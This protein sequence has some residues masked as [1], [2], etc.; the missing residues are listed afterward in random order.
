MTN[1]SSS[2]YAPA[3]VDERMAAEIIGVAP[4]T[5]RAFRSQRRGPLFCRIG[6][7]IVYRLPDLEAY[8]A[9]NTVSP[10]I[11]E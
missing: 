5:L 2:R 6:R 10:E 3:V 4:S 11:N 8:L 9:E 1:R 7:R